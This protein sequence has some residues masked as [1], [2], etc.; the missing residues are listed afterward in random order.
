M[1]IIRSGHRQALSEY[2]RQGKPLATTRQIRM[3][4]DPELPI[5]SELPVTRPQGRK[6]HR[7]EVS[8]CPLSQLIALWNKRSSNAAYRNR[9]NRRCFA[10]QPALEL[11]LCALGYLIAMMLPLVHISGDAIEV[12]GSR[13]V[14]GWH[15]DVHHCAARRNR[16]EGSILIIRIVISIENDR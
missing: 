8:T 14:R 2:R 15:P 7:R 12:T 1:H 5:T 13:V 3:V 10:V 9:R 11:R 6:E 16:M 4:G